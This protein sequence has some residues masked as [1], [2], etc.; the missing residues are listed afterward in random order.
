MSAESDLERAIVTLVRGTVPSQFKKAAITL[1][2]RLQRDLGLDS[3]GIAALL[4]QLEA[5]FGLDLFN[6]PELPAKMSNL[7]SVGDLIG[8]AA[9]LRR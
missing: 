7:R 1:E 9:S 8:L 2:M 3:L 5:E 4:F 6:D